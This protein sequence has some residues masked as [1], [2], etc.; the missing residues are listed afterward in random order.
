MINALAGHRQNNNDA[1]DDDPVDDNNNQDDEPNQNNVPSADQA[2]RADEA[3]I[4]CYNRCMPK[5]FK[6]T[7]VLLMLRIGS[8]LLKGSSKQ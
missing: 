2:D 5:E 3:L 7:S 4:K 1:Q 6:G 8:G